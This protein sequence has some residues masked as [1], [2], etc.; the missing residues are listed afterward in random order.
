MTGLLYR[1]QL[2]PP[3][4]RMSGSP[5]ARSGRWRRREAVGSVM[6]GHAARKVMQGGTRTPPECYSLHEAVCPNAANTSCGRLLFEEHTAERTTQNFCGERSTAHAT[7]CWRL[8]G[9][10]RCLPAIF[11]LGEM[12]CGTTSL[13]A[14]LSQHPLLVPPLRKEPRFFSASSW[15]ARSLGW[16]ASH[17]RAAAAR[18]D[19]MTLD[20]SPTYLGNLRAVQWLPKWLPEARLL[21]L[22]RHPVRRA[23]SQW[24]MGA[25]LLRASPACAGARRATFAPHTRQL[26]FARLAAACLL[27]AALRRCGA[28][29]RFDPEAFAT[30]LVLVVASRPGDAPSTPRVAHARRAAAYYPLTAADAAPNS[31]VSAHG[32]GWS[33]A[34]LE[35]CVRRSGRHPHALL[36]ELLWRN[37]TAPPREATAALRTLHHCSEA[38]LLPPS[39]LARGAGY[40][41]HLRRWAAAYPPG[42]LLVL[43]TEELQQR[44]AAVLRRA[45]AFLGLPPLAPSQPA[46]RYCV[47]RPALAAASRVQTVAQ[48]QQERRQRQR[49]WQQL[50]YSQTRAVVTAPL[51][52][53]IGACGPADADAESDAYAAEGVEGVEG[54]EGMGGAV[55]EGVEGS[56]PGEVMSR[57]LWDALLAHFAPSVVELN[58]WLAANGHEDALKRTS[59]W[60]AEPHEPLAVDL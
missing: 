34:S 50:N 6:E 54:V 18:T 38:L 32:I 12:K 29:S 30:A 1:G 45:I 19:A 8:H 51:L 56:Q 59:R 17:F 7:P 3:P 52:P 43:T 41:R 42:Q 27:H 4:P 40:A 58:E 14:Q 9:R 53:G 33:N 2:E 48:P 31:A 60:M 44:P 21:V 26:R 5:S 46:R 10:L 49:R 25:S 35:R 28:A 15:K 39:M 55:I 24:R 16:Y 47:T 22:V 36:L 11:I 37:L 57:A 13:F 23:V 20:A